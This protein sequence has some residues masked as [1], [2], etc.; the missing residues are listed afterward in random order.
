MY[1]RYRKAWCRVTGW[2]DGPI[3]WPRVQQV[4]VRGRPGLLVNA[5]LERAV[6][7]ESGVALA[8]WFGL[9]PKPVS[10]WRRAFGVDKRARVARRKPAHRVMVGAARTTRPVV[11]RWTAVELARLGTDTDN[12]VAAALGR[13]VSAVTRQRSRRGVRPFDVPSA[14]PW[15]PAEVALLGTDTDGA[16]A[17]RTGRTAV[18]VTSKRLALRVLAF[19]GPAPGA[20]PPVR[21]QRTPRSSTH[22]LEN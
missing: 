14:R 6:R 4:G 3:R 7:T 1:C 21:L 17:A 12:A 13:S 10:W 19:T 18:A 5:T 15:T 2:G 16:I 9:S 8:H 20:A 22:S 11:V